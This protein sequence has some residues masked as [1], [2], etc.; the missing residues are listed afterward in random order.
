LPLPF[1]PPQ[2]AAIVEH[3]LRRRV[4]HPVV[5]LARVPWL[6]RALDEA[7]V[8]TEVV[9]DGILPGRELG[10]VVVEPVH[11]ELADLHSGKR[12]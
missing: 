6:P 11:D 10:P 12:L 8:E 9:P 5:A 1:P 7:V 3:V 4:Q 2:E